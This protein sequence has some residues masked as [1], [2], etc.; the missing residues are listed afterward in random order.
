MDG[1]RSVGTFVRTFEV[2]HPL[3]KD[4]LE[5]DVPEAGFLRIGTNAAQAAVLPGGNVPEHDV[6]E[7]IVA[8]CVEVPVLDEGAMPV[9]YPPAP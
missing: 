7:R 5:D 1:N 9:P 2:L 6:V 4:R 3:G 8:D